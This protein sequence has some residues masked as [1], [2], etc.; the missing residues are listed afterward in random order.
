M[1]RRERRE[2]GYRSRDEEHPRRVEPQSIEDFKRALREEAAVSAEFDLPLCVV[3]ASSRS[4]WSPETEHRVVG[5]L[6]AGDLVACPEHAEIC[7]ALPNTE[8]ADAEAVERR[9][10]EILPEAATG[11]AVHRA[12]DTVPD[13]LSRARDATG[14]KTR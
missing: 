8:L 6:R 2:G 7:V 14:R 1:D 10:R 12:G 13:L 3:V 11:I 5:V 9:L 4:G